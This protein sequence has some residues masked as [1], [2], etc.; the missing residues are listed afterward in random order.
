MVEAQRRAASGLAG[1]QRAMANI[2]GASESE[3]K[4][5]KESMESTSIKNKNNTQPEPL[6]DQ[7]RKGL[8]LFDLRCVSFFLL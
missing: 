2:G 7:E 1:K 6:K 5:R 8:C 4:N 3:N